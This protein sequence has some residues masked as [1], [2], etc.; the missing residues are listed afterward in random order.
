[1]LKAGSH[2]GPYIIV[3]PLGAG[4][5]GEVYR[6][7]DPRVDRDV[8][9]KVSTEQFTDRF[10]REVRAIAA[11]NHPNI[12]TLYDVG[13]DYLVMELV[14]G[15]T[16]ADKIKQGSIPLMESLEIARQITEA[17]DAAHQKGIVHRDLK[18][19]N[20][21]VRPDGTVK[22]LDFG[23][24]KVGVAAGSS[25]DDSPTRS[26]AETQA[27]MVLG[28]TAYMSPEQ[29]E[30][31]PLDARSDLFALGIVL[32]EML[33]GQR[34][35]Q[36]GTTL[37]TLASILR[38]KPQA[39]RQLR[40]GLPPELE[41]L[42]MRCLA[43]QPE[44]RYA[45]AAEVRLAL[46]QIGKRR[47]TGIT[48]GRPVILAM[49][50]VLVA[51][52]GIGTYR[53][54]TRTERVR[55]ADTVA[56]PQAARLMES[57]RPLA[58]LSLLN[59]AEQY[60]PA[61]PE[62]IR[63]KE[64]LRPLSLA[65]ETVPSGA[66]IY[67]TDYSGPGADDDGQWQHL[68]RSPLKTD[69]LPRGGYFRIRAL[70]DG[71]AR[72]ERAATVIAPTSV[73]GIKIQLHK[74]E[75]T[76]PGMVWIPP[77]STG[78]LQVLG[79]G[80]S[81]VELPAAWMDKYEVTNSQF[82]AFVDAGGY[83][84]REYWQGPF[85]KEGKELSWEEAMTEFRDPT[86]RPGP[87]T[88]EGGTYPDGRGDFPVGGVSWYEADAYARF[89]GKSLPTLYEWYVAAGVG[90]NS[91]II[92]LSNFG[93][94]GPA[95]VGAHLGMSPF[96]TYD[97]AGNVKE[98]CANRSGETHYILGGAWSESSYM[99]QQVDSRSPFAREA[100]F[101]VRCILHV[102]QLPEALRGPIE[103]VS[104]D[105]R[106]DKPVDES[107]F[108]IYKSLLS[109]D[110]T[111]LKAAELSVTDAP[112]WRR[113]KLSIQA[114]YGNER[115]PIYLY[116]PKNAAAPYQAV[117]YYGGANVMMG[118]QTP[119]EVSTRL[120]E[121]IIKSGRAVVLPVYAGT[122]ERGPTPFPTPPALARDLTIQS[123]KDVARSIDYLETRADID[124]S[125][126]GYYGL[127]YGSLEG[128]IVLAAEPRFKAAVLMSLGSTPKQSAEV[129]MWNYAPRVRLPVLIL[130]GRDDSL[131]PLE[132]SQVPLFNALG[133]PEQDKRQI[134]Y[135]GGHV[136]FIDRSE[137]IKEALAW[138]DRYLGPVSSK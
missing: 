130:N 87:S 36:G 132:S 111:D 71:F 120:M 129:D 28:T 2:V 78:S 99:F 43:K 135:P 65:I 79:L 84:K 136:D 96:G 58:A 47:S 127:S 110:R 42:V 75:E 107:T 126:L 80:L 19:G 106:N 112:H 3:S 134:I 25:S 116:L 16:L 23:L 14:E 94:E 38:E 77:S 114:A 91:Q 6:A 1:M 85:V 101:G 72:A 92:S 98:W 97:M 86:G 108:Q 90:A 29:A 37:S 48:L 122:L 63:L 5:M 70:K 76:P 20:I 74:N 21:K 100:T 105:R 118:P 69:R 24:A 49:A 133:T 8:A 53:W 50:I 44:E 11:L 60:V 124:T 81:A 7:H 67:A 32:Y 39:P 10:A 137:V 125:R 17:L 51:V 119:E 18:P 93:G 123:F 121:Y 128:M 13:R 131:F 41:I 138:F 30:G 109:Y 56:L 22:V 4:G 102:E 59:Q 82:K 103:K 9:I 89:T 26:V 52:I 68:G 40:P 35:F 46:E 55:W 73:R 64:D 15:P 33:C 27:G 62:L 54:Y 117:F 66:E 31:R 83:G 57:S 113:E 115:L 88:W 61:S 12:C 34:P 45:S 104:F 95:P